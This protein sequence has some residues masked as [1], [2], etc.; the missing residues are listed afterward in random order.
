M[1]IVHSQYNH[2][3]LKEL[4]M[5]K[6][7]Q[8]VDTAISNTYNYFEE[9]KEKGVACVFF[10]PDTRMAIVRALEVDG[11]TGVCNY[12]VILKHFLPAN[13]A[14]SNSS[15]TDGNILVTVEAA[16]TKLNIF[17]HKTRFIE[18]ALDYL[19]YGKE[20]PRHIK[21]GV[22]YFSTFMETAD[23]TPEAVLNKL[24][25]DDEFLNQLIAWQTEIEPLDMLPI[26]EDNIRDTFNWT[27]SQ[28]DENRSAGAMFV[29]DNGCFL[30]RYFDITDTERDFLIRHIEKRFPCIPH[31][32]ENFLEIE[33]C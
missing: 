24:A 8:T 27:F 10:S 2:F 12:M 1:D 4:K 9:D 29:G 5:E 7:K 28:L 33:I 32:G 3:Q 14:L 6:F 23:D 31:P 26:T 16:H 21:A 22:V 11:S 20:A 25:Y 18:H 19:R 15:P 13:Y 30:L 17:R